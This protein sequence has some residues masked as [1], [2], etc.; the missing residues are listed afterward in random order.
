MEKDGSLH[1]GPT[2]ESVP[3]KADM[4]GGLESNGGHQDDHRNETPP[5]ESWSGKMDFI[6][7]CVGYSIGLGNVW[8]FPY[9]CY[10]N[11]GGKFPQRTEWL[12]K[13]N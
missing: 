12:S 5:R 2:P 4:K 7:S 10:T 3:L 1:N 8:R 11:G 13:Q 9:L 6:F